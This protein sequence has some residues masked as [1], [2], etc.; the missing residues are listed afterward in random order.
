MVHTCKAA[1][2]WQGHAQHG[3]T[4]EHGA[5]SVAE[6]GRAGQSVAESTLD[7]R[8]KKGLRRRASGDASKR[9]RVARRAKTFLLRVR[10]QTYEILVTDAV[11]ETSSATALAPSTPRLQSAM[12]MLTI[13]LPFIAAMRSSEAAWLML[14]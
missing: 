3:S 7:C 6:H 9:R 8:K 14:L 2:Q 12:P 1:R 5:W 10:G 13:G 11:T 4:A